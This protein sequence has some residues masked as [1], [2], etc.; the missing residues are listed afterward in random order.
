MNCCAMYVKDQ[1][2]GRNLLRWWSIRMCCID[3]LAVACV[4]CSQCCLLWLLITLSIVGTRCCAGQVTQLM[5]NRSTL[6][7]CC[8]G[9]LH[10]SWAAAIVDVVACQL[11]QL[12]ALHHPAGCQAAA[13]LACPWYGVLLWLLVIGVSSTC[14]MRSGS[15]EGVMPWQ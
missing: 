11:L 15:W 1:G 14:S 4:V 3:C 10:A 2:I 12:Q 8:C 9:T 7:L 5:L 13:V 6:M